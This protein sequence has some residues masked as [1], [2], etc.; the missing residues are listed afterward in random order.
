MQISIIFAIVVVPVGVFINYWTL[1]VTPLL[2]ILAFVLFKR[3]GFDLV[4]IRAIELSIE[5][6][7]NDFAGWGRLFP[8]ARERA[9]SWLAASMAEPD[10]R[11]M[12]LYI[13]EDRRAAISPFFEPS[14]RSIA[15]AKAVESDIRS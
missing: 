13:P 8:E 11:L 9:I 6:L 12:A 14:A 10:E 4:Q 2:L 15:T 5:I 3:A 7:A 1:I